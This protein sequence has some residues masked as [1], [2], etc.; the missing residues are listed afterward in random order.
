MAN[1]NKRGTRKTMQTGQ[2]SQTSSS[3]TGRGSN[4]TD[5]ARAKGGRNS[6]RRGGTSS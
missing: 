1:T 5:E 2:G 6:S 4:L 3:T